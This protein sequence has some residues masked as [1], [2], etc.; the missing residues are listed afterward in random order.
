MVD[1]L[2]KLQ[3]IVVLIPTNFVC[4][5]VGVHLC[6]NRAVSKPTEWVLALGDVQGAHLAMIG[7]TKLLKMLADME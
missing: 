6:P 1:G 4:G 7:V 3:F 2:A 5:S